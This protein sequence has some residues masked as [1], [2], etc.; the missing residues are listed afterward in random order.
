MSQEE[1]KKS[2]DTNKNERL[3]RFIAKISVPLL[4]V[5]GVLLVGAVAFGVVSSVNDKKVKTALGELDVI[6]NALQE[7]R[8]NLKDAEL[9]S[10][11]NDL[12]EKLASFDT[13]KT[14]VLAV[15]SHM[16]KAEIKYGQ[17][18]FDQ[19][20]D[21][22][23]LAASADEKAYTSAIC[24][25]QAAVCEEELGNFDGAVA[26]YKKA[27]DDDSMPLKTHALFSIGRVEES[28]GNLTL[29]K[30]AY[31]A[32]VAFSPNDNWAT[33]AKSRLLQLEASGKL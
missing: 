29:A 23:L 22:W 4:I 31:D 20:R 21:E 13:Y 28:R 27:S 14:G 9:T 19:A 17:K 16:L 26:N 33:L 18:A 2:D 30:E 24:Y 1:L 12:Y 3:N 8:V 15:R 11:E 25:Y 6:T 10:K 32:L 5:I 7:A